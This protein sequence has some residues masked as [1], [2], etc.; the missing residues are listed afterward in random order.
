MNEL[1]RVHLDDLETLTGALLTSINTEHTQELPVITDKI[2]AKDA[3][4]QQAA[5]KRM[6]HLLARSFVVT[7]RSHVP[8][9]LCVRAVSEHERLHAQVAAMEEELQLQSSRIV[10]FASELSAVEQK[11]HDAVAANEQSTHK[12][13]DGVYAQ[14]TTDSSRSPSTAFAACNFPR[15][16]YFLL[17]VLHVHWC[18][19]SQRASMWSL[20]C[21]SP[22]GWV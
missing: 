19:T 1:V 15:S 17:L 22:S 12:S 11:L 7:S 2:L 16:V 8:R 5:A 21:C 6:P 13:I 3:L 4:L 9:C 20:F 10:Q 18:V 14:R